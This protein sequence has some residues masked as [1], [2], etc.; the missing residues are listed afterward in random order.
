MSL[1]NNELIHIG[2]KEWCC[3][4]ELELP[5]VKAKIDTGAKTSA[6]HAF[7][8]EPFQQ[9]GVEYVKFCIHPLQRNNTLTRQCIAKVKDRRH[10][11]SSNGAKEERFVIATTISL[12][13]LAPKWMIEI[14]LSDRDPLRFRMLLGREALSHHVMIEPGASYLTGRISKNTVSDSYSEPK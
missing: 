2:W 3:L 12:G 4:P 14:T 10:V 7:E 8:I 9:D 1:K 13:K 11:M 5:F 6:L